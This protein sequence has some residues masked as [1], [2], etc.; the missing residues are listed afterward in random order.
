VAFALADGGVGHAQFEP[1][2][3]MDERLLDLVARIQ[4]HRDAALSA[5]Y[6][7]GIPNRLRIKLKDG[8]ELVREV[9]FPR[10]HA[11]NPM[12]D[13]E[14]EGKFHAEAAR[15]LSPAQRADLLR[16]WSLDGQNSITNM[17]RL[18]EVKS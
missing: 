12:T 6:P 1:A 3:F 11:R 7:A 18:C 2:R 8:R 4:V 15:H 17:L 9:E 10:G 14:V 16:V 5:R 13:V